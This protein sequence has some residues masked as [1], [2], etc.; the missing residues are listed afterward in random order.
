MALRPKRKTAA[1]KQMFGRQRGGE[2]NTNRQPANSERS[3]RSPK[4]KYFGH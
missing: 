3:F 2:K 1:A 4:G